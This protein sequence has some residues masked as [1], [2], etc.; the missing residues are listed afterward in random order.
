MLDL[1]QAAKQRLLTLKTR[2]SKTD[3]RV[4]HKTHADQEEVSG[5]DQG[6]TNHAYVRAKE[7]LGWKQRSLDRIFNKVLKHGLDHNDFSGQFSRYLKKKFKKE[8]ASNRLLIH[9]EVLYLL[10]DEVL[11]TLY[12][13]PNKYVRYLP[14]QQAA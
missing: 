9:G 7:R 4:V 1:N 12:R 14:E 13:L 6:I 8:T 11:I 5:Q 3:L 10:R 2:Q